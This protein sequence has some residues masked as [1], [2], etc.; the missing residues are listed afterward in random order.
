MKFKVLSNL[1]R[2]GTDYK[3]GDTIGLDEKI[4]MNLVAD[5][6]LVLITE[7][8]PPAS[9]EE[10]KEEGEDEENGEGTD[11]GDS[12]TGESEDKGLVETL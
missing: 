2:N 12:N 11:V 7:L 9:E 8:E 10:K 3:K 1:N 4:G 6:I 5:G